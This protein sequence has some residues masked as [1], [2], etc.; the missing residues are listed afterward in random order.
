MQESRN[1]MR[2]ASTR[3]FL[4][5]VAGAL[6]ILIFHQTVLQ[7]FFW[8]GWSPHPAFR[9]A[10]VPPFNAPLVASITFWGAVYGGVF[11]FL[12]PFTMVPLW[13]RGMAAGFCAMILAWFLFLPLMGQPAAFDWQMWPM[14]R[15]FVAYQL[16]GVGL[17]LILPVL[18]PRPMLR[19]P[20]KLDGHNLA[21]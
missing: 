4:G 6:S 2:R 15:S 9:V 18:R 1:A 16:W 12:L 8:L 10:H 14:L 21:V 7:I 19:R 13:L 11:G 20:R 5:S 3:I 17:A